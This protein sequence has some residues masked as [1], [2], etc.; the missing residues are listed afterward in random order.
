MIM[1]GNSGIY[2]V[3]SF[4]LLQ[5]F[6]IKLF[7]VLASASLCPVYAVALN[8]LYRK[9]HL[10]IF[11]KLKSGI[12]LF[13]TQNTKIG[14]AFEAGHSFLRSNLIAYDMTIVA[15]LFYFCLI[16]DSFHPYLV[17]CLA[18]FV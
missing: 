7:V 13:I 17:V 16:A 18:Y 12:F 14:V 9:A 4:F 15:V 3:V 2:F 10:M 1:N 5:V 8:F 6:G 11:Y